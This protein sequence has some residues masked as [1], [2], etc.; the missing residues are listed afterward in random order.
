M[1]LAPDRRSIVARGL[2]ALPL[3]AA[4]SSDR[5]GA[6]P[7]SGPNVLMIV[8]DTLRADHLGCYGYERATS[9]AIDA[10]AARGTRFD[11]AYT[12]AP[13]T[14]PSV[15]S[16]LSGLHPTSHGATHYKLGLPAEVPLL[17]EI[18]RERGYRTGAVI[19]G[20]LIGGRFGFD[21]GWDVFHED[22]VRGQDHVSTPGVTAKAKELLRELA[23][24]EEPF[25]LFAHYFDPH[26]N[27]KRHPEHA[28]APPSAGRLTGDEP[29]KALRRMDDLTADEVGLVVDIYDEEIRYTDDGVAE[30]LATLRELGLEDETLVL[31]TADHG[32]EFLSHGWL[33]HVTSLYEDL[34]RVPL[35]AAGP[36]LRSGHVVEWPVSL[37]A[38][39]PTVLELLRIPAGTRSFQGES[40]APF[41]FPGRDDPPAAPVFFEVDMGDWEGGPDTFKKGLVD[42]RYKLIRD[43]VTGEVELYD[44]RA[45]PGERSNVAA[46][47]PDVAARYGDLLERH[48]ARVTRERAAT[49]E[50]ELGAEDLEMLSGLGYAGDDR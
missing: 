5:G 28:F 10:L 42:A 36:G 39:T 4:C 49:G 23:D 18:L 44:L 13:W 19:S 35:I 34:V 6:E 33:G 46:S 16:M 14:M 3:L 24:G 37:V 15:A 2:L 7:R 29:A 26:E 25:F 50:R 31:F 41:L 22:E 11:R 43:D 20:F 45:D 47:K 27:F 32:E 12:A 9:P 8:V 40:L 48:R 1:E 21:R 17:P 30:L 38:L